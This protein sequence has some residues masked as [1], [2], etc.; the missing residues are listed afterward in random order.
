LAELIA[1]GAITSIEEAEKWIA[2]HG[3]GEKT[4]TK[5]YLAKLT[6]ET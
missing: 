4:G 6:D 5:K 2:S 1:T 3:T